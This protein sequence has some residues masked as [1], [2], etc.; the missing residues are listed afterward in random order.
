MRFIAGYLRDFVTAE[1]NRAFYLIMIA[2]LSLCFFINYHFHFEDRYIESAFGTTAY[3]WRRLVSYA[4]PYYFTALLYALCYKNHSYLH[5]PQFWIK[6]LMALILISWSYAAD[7]YIPQLLHHVPPEDWYYGR[8]LLLN[9][10]HIVSTMVPLAFYY[11]LAEKEPSRFYGFK[12]QGFNTWPYL[13]M[14][15]IMLPLILWASFQPDF[16]QTYPAYRPGI[17]ELT[18]NIPPWQTCGLY[19]LL[20]CTD[21]I[22][23]ELLYRGL[24][25]VGMAAIM[26]RASVFPMVATYAFLHFGKPIAE[27]ISSIAG[28]FI[29][30][31]IA[32]Y[33]RSIIGGII[34][35]A[36]IALGMDM[37]AFWQLGKMAA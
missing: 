33:T 15:C 30:G 11:V 18:H 3:F 23:I 25:V 24:L 34:I 4:L 2:F 19:E 7:A 16:M 20:Y 27:A 13:I 1:S 29:L 14:L 26:G 12:L 10:L 31:V 36:G 32:Y 22:T 9:G 17:L 35:H 5:N 28:G 21:F 8:K 37:A 6:S